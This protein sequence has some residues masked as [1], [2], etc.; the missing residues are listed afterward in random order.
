MKATSKEYRKL[1]RKNR[2]IKSRDIRHLLS[3]LDSF[4]ETVVDII[5]DEEEY[6]EIKDYLEYAKSMTEKSQNK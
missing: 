2:Y 5:R 4:L 1:C 3:D 6:E